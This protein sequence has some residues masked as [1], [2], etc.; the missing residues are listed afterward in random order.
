M[1]I[2][3]DRQGQKQRPASLPYVVEDRDAKTFRVSRRV[4]VDPQVLAFERQKVFDRV[5]LYLGHESEIPN[6]HD[7]KSRSVG[8]RAVIF[9]RDS[10]EELQCYLNTCTHRGA[11]VCREKSGNGRFFRCFYHAWTFNTDGQLV[12]MPDEDS[13]GP[14]FDKSERS[15]VR[16]ARMDTYRGFVFISFN[17]QVPTLEEYLG[18]ARHS[19]AEEPQRP[20]ILSLAFS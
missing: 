6:R 9:C 20:L 5:W 16:P 3:E 13:Y 1:T 18:D 11:T 17:S 10:Q 12:A 14:S 4:M 7:F 19:Q 15:L 8:G 2:T